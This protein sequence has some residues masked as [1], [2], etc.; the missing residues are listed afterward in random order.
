MRLQVSTSTS[1]PR[2]QQTNGSGLFI[3]GRQQ[4]RHKVAAVQR[5][6]PF[7]SFTTLLCAAG[8]PFAGSTRD[9]LRAQNAGKLK[10]FVAGLSAK[11]KRSGPPSPRS[12]WRLL[13]NRS[14]LLAGSTCPAPPGP[15]QAAQV[16]N[17]LRKVAR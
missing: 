15:N 6:P 2:L 10:P 9:R 7:P 5:L 13:E 4:G 3:A 12:L 1:T 8:S 16:Y 11:E 14:P 17:R